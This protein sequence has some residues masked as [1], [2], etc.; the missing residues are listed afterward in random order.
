MTSLNISAHLKK[1]RNIL[2]P[3]WKKHMEMPHLLQKHWVIL[4]EQKA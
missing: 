3:L 2:K 1:W 4:P